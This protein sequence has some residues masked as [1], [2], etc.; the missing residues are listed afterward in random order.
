MDLRS[1]LT[2]PLSDF[3]DLPD[4]PGGKHFYGKI[5]GVE[6][7]NSSQKGTPFY[8]FNVRFTDPGKDVTKEELDKITS[9]GFSLADYQPY[10]SF[11]LTP[12]AMKIIRRFM[13]SL[14][15]PASASIVEN[16]SLDD[17]FNPTAATIEKIRGLDV[18]CRT[19]KADEQGRVYMNL[20]SIAGT[21]RE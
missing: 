20:D 4:L 6:S 14:G 21:K 3:P 12:A 16:L 2:S 9:A 1:L 19:Q 5:V 11:Y 10:A 18:L 15:F 17:N 7:K 13:D 8:Q